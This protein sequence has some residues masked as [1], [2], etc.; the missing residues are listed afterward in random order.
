ME[1]LRVKRFFAAIQ[2]IVRKI[3]FDIMHKLSALYVFLVIMF[4]LVADCGDARLSIKAAPVFLFCNIYPPPLLYSSRLQ[5]TNQRKSFDQQYQIIIQNPTSD[6][7]VYFD[8]FPN[9]K[10]NMEK[11]SIIKTCQI[12][13]AGL[14]Y[15]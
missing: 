6:V 2:F 12:P 7:A 9:A 10:P 4:I 14:V 11:A 1:G 15:N 8:S 13:A 5:Q 3:L